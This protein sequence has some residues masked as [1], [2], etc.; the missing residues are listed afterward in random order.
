MISRFKLSHISDISMKL[1]IV[2]SL[3]QPIMEYCGEVWGPG[4]LRLAKGLDHILDNPLQKVQ[5]M[6]LHEFG[7]LRKTVP[8]TILHREMRRA[9]VV[10][11]WLRSILNLWE[12]L[13]LEPKDGNSSP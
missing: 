2:S 10:K 13:R 12:R 9:P 7:H 1:S 6:F 4:L 11:G 3:V 8:T 5:N